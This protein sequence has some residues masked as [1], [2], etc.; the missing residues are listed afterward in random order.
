VA[1]GRPVHPPLTA[2]N[3][4]RIR[5]SPDGRRVVTLGRKNLL[6]DATTATVLAE[7]GPYVFNHEPALSPDGKVLAVTDNAGRFQVFDTETGRPVD[8]PV[9]PGAWNQRPKFSPDGTALATTGL[10][11]RAVQVWD[12]ATGERR[13]PP[14]AR[15]LPNANSYFSPDARSVAVYSVGTTETVQ[16]W[17][18]ASGTPLS[19]V[20]HFGQPPHTLRFSPDGRYL[21]ASCNDGNSHV[22]DLAPDARPVEE[23]VSHAQLLANRKLD[24]RG[25][26]VSL[27]R[28]EDQA[29]W[30]V[31][32]RAP[33]ER[34]PAAK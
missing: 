24:D 19:P 18:V 22:F 34:A 2:P 4:F 13:G 5:V 16:L 7:L 8:S 12:V 9:A 27:S 11:D 14:L 30:A 28:E 20:Y 6:W 23:I 29:L 15:G 33:G 1:A 3:T 21:L 26:L 31:V 32:R 25:V 10:A 17:D